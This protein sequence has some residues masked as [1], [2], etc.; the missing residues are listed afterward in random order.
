MRILLIKK[1]SILH[2]MNELYPLHFW[3]KI[4]NTSFHYK[5][6]IFFLWPGFHS[7]VWKFFII[8]TSILTWKTWKPMVVFMKLENQKIETWGI[9]RADRPGP[10][11]R[12][13]TQSFNLFFCLV[14]WNHPSARCVAAKSVSWN[15]L[16]SRSRNLRFQCIW[17]SSFMKPPKVSSFPVKTVVKPWKI[18][19][20]V[21]ET[22]SQKKMRCFY[23]KPQRKFGDILNSNVSI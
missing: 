8:F 7:L 6:R 3:Q 18:S 11:P 23:L 4:S 12:N 20:Q 5:P 14:S 1:V 2:H 19:K 21:N 16:R 13:L 10:P 9:L 15:H 17:F 22:R